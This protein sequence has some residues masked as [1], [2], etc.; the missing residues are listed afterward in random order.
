VN[1]LEQAAW[2]RSSRKP[3]H[4]YAEIARADS[5]G[6]LGEIRRNRGAKKSCRMG[7]EGRAPGAESLFDCA[8]RR[9]LTSY[10]LP[11]HF[12][13]GLSLHSHLTQFLYRLGSDF[14]LDARAMDG[15]TVLVRVETLFP[16]ETF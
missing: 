7:C 13:L 10:S 9:A 5:T 1:D 2:Q 11:K 16:I 4:Y 12:P 14:F 3:A 6:F 15:Q 8:A